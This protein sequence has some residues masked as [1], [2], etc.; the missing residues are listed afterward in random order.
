MKILALLDDDDLLQE[1][2]LLM[3]VN[4]CTGLELQ[5]VAKCWYGSSVKDM[6]TDIVLTNMAFVFRPL[7]MEQVAELLPEEKC[8]EPDDG[9]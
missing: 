5:T 1:G 9:K 4:F 8:I 2:D 7:T 6:L 3:K